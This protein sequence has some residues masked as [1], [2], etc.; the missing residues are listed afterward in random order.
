ME[1]KGMMGGF[2][3]ISEWIM[4]LSVTNILW[5]ICSIPFVAVLVPIMFAETNDQV[6]SNLILSAV[7]APF[8]LFPA[9]AALFGVTRKWVMG[10][11]DAP[12]LK[13][14]FKNYKESYKQAMLGGILYAVLFAVLV[15]DFRVYLDK[16]GSWGIISYL[17]LALMVLVGVSLLNFFSML[18]HYHMKTLQLLKNALL[19]TIGRPI[20]SLMTVIMCGF[21]LYISFSSA[22]L[23]FLVPFFTMSIVGA[24]AFWNFYG[25][26]TK[27]QEQAQKAADAEAEEERLRLEEDAAIMLPNTED[28]HTTIK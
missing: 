11:V 15:V 10:E 25:I 22:K 12:L 3:K 13:T 9:T 27:L 28:G 17:F 16:L 24:I 6:L 5:L 20:R 1:M 2:Y 14:F 18:V 4:R 21:V 23:M 19:I 26:Y 7:L 8:T